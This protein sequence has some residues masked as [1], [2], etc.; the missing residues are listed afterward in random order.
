MRFQ[1]FLISLAAQ[2]EASVVRSLPGAVPVIGDSVKHFGLVVAG[3]RSRN[4]PLYEIA[5]Q[6][7][8]AP[9]RVMTISSC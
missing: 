7:I 1:S 9:I 8:L 5:A 3:L 2:L 4:L 6:M